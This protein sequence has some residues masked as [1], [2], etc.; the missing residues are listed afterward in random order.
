MLEYSPA[1]G[2]WAAPDK[3]NFTILQLDHKMRGNSLPLPKAA[4][5]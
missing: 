5:K 3:V 1:V 4:L 2:Q